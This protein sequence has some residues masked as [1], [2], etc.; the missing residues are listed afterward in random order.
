LTAIG[1]RLIPIGALLLESSAADSELRHMLV[2][3]VIIG[4]TIIGVS[5]GILILFFRSFE[6]E[7]EGK[8][9]FRPT[10]LM[11]AL[12]ASILAGCLILLMI[13]FLR[14]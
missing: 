5:T 3:V 8:A 13:S 1:A 9:N 12:I 4:T 14:R 11:I 6:K 2:R 7:G 10:L